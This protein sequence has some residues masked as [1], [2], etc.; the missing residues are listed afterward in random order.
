MPTDGKDGQ[1][2]IGFVQ[3]NYEF[4]GQHYLPLSVGMLKAYLRKNADRPARYRFLPV[5]FRREKIEEAA[6]LLAG[7]DI[8]AFSVYSWNINLSL[9]IARRLRELNP[10]VLTVFGGPQVP[11]RAGDFLRDNP[12]IDIVCHGEGEEVFK[13]VADRA[14]S[15]D[16]SGVPSVSYLR[17]DGSCVSAARACRVADLDSLPSPFLDGTFDELAAE[18]PGVKWLGLLETNRG[19]PFACAFCEWGDKGMNRVYAFGL[20][21]VRAEIDW[22][23]RHAVEFVFCCDA[24]FGLLPRDVEIAGFV[25]DARKRTGYPHTF[26]LQ[27]SKNA[28]ERV[29]RIQKL[30]A[31]SGLNKG[32]LFA[33][34]SVHPETLELIHRRNISLNSFDELQR[35]FKRDG[36]PTF[37][38][39]I[40][41]LPG[42]TYDSFADGVDGIIS[43]GQHNRVQFNILSILQ[44]SAMGD[45]AYRA[46]H[47][48][49]TVRSELANRYGRHSRD[50]EEVLEYQDLVVATAAMPAEDWVRAMTFAWLAS[51]L[52]FD[53]LLQLPSVLLNAEAGVRYRAIFEAFAACPAGE[54]PVTAGVRSFFE[55]KAR[56]IRRGEPEYCHA[57]D[58]LDIWW[59][60]DEHAYIGLCRGGKLDDF[61]AEA[62]RLLRGLAAERGA[63][64]PWLDDALRLNRELIKLPFLYG[65]KEVALGFNVRE[66]H[67]AA[68]AGARLPLRGAAGSCAVDRSSPRW[69]NWED[70]M[71]EVVWFGNKTRNYLY[72]CGDR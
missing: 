2:T 1:L 72:A 11:S 36:I 18:N 51:F 66:S 20:E 9:A 71:K 26:S 48:L 35:L 15:R 4:S 23:A 30:L 21:R 27:A 16:W 5:L 34:Q 39:V 65:K 8:A 13:A 44:N 50:A 14:A 52:H 19:C 56:A 63:G 64:V 67:A 59:M 10:S 68:L 24:N 7:A 33:L 25:A 29:Y 45:P 46:R 54:F 47:G 37:T 58:W 3:I 32:A 40:V 42:E 43:K 22:L 61:Y 49:V 60:T 57:P 28:P 38:D 6:R 62:G 70:W 41:G 53:K 31:D 55:E 17:P 69:D 12:F